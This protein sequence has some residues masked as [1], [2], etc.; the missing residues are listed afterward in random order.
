MPVGGYQHLR[1]ATV[2]QS[3]HSGVNDIAS[4][5]YEKQ[6]VRA[7]LASGVV[8]SLGCCWRTLWVGLPACGAAL[9]GLLSVADLWGPGRP[10]HLGVSFLA[11]AW[12]E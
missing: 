7:Q 9:G 12:V 8:S 3:L 2:V 6:G 11:S 10:S 5:R 4:L 1:A